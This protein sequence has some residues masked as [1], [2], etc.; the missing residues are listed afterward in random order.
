[1]M[2]KKQM[3]RMVILLQLVVNRKSLPRK[4]VFKRE[5]IQ[6]LQKMLVLRRVVL[7]YQLMPVKKV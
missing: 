6:L 7:G 4:V 5:M 1:M 2:K 3:K